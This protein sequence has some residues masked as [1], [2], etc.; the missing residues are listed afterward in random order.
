MAAI[1]KPMTAGAIGVSNIMLIVVKE[2]TKEIGI[3]KVLGAT[4]PGIVLMLSNEFAKWVLI[5]NVIAWPAGYFIM[6]HWLERFAY[7]TSLDWWLFFT[8]GL[9]AL[10]M[11][12]LTVS[13]Q[14]MRA[15]VINPVQ[16]IRYE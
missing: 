16:S 4:V 15:A 8:A 12:M 1:R 5:A 14:A 9:G 13:Y 10:M 7:K 3:R 11:A 2:R 6:K